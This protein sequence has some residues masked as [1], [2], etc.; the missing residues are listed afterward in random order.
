[1]GAFVNRQSASRILFAI[2][3]TYQQNQLERKAKSVKTSQAKPAK[4]NSAHF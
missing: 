1:M 3:Q 4:I 2:A